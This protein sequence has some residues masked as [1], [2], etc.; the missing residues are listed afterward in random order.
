M[1]TIRVDYVAGVKRPTERVRS[2]TKF[3]NIA[4]K[5][6]LEKGFDT[7][8]YEDEGFDMSTGYNGITGVSSV[9]LGNEISFR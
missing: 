8:S 4:K 1:T 5:I 6:A 3:R 9:V 7:A 2:V